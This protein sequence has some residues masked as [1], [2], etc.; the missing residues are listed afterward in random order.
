MN[1]SAYDETT[2]SETREA[3]PLMEQLLVFDL[4]DE[5]DQLRSE[6]TWQ[7][8][9]R[10]SRMLAKDV[11]FRVLLTAL[12]PGASVV[13]KDGDSRVSV[14]VIEGTVL[15]RL[16]DDTTELTAGQIAAIDSGNPWTLEALDDSVILLT[17]AWPAEK[18]STT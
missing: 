4:M 17:L 18:A 16:R 1:T 3:R 9:D 11:D 14:Q 12:R 2:G 6:P 5:I 15:A 10:N 7:Q 13:E 8:G